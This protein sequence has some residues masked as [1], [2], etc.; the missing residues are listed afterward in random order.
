MNVTLNQPSYKQ[1]PIRSIAVLA[2]LLN[3][4]EKRLLAIAEDAGKSYRLA[5]PIKKPDGSIRQP[6]DAL[7]PL[8]GIQRTIKSEILARVKFP[9]YLTGSLKGSD[10]RVNAKLHLGAKIA[11]CEDIEGFFPS[12]SKNRI[13]DVWRNFFNFPDDVATCLTSLT[14][15]DES[16][17]QGAITSSYL[18]NLALWR[19]E[20]QLELSIRE[21]GFVYSRYVDDITVS[22]RAFMGV[23]EKTQ[24]IGA[25]YGMLRGYEYRPKR[26]KHEILTSG[27]RMAVTKLVMNR[28]LGIPVQERSRI[29]SA[30]FQL[31]LRLKAGERNV[32]VAKL[33][34]SVTGRV[35][36]LST[37]HPSDGAPLKAKMAN[38]R[39]L[40]DQPKLAGS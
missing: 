30:V 14:T 34:R 33:F 11:I 27:K 3:C 9:P 35:A 15:K 40:L 4:T 26:R 28:K 39:S 6:F 16:L 12:T 25:V 20:P 10:Y 17:P 7:E 5:K 24:T 13:W 21:K 18:A 37:F 1:K 2:R 38:L 32:E 23:S 8:K 29:R 19:A 36:R 31:G 22:S